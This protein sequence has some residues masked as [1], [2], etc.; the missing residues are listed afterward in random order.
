MRRLKS[1]KLFIVFLLAFISLLSYAVITYC[2]FVADVP[3]TSRSGVNGSVVT[4]DDEK[5]DFY[6]YNSLNYTETNGTLPSGNDQDIYNISNMVKAKITYSGIDT[7]NNN[8]KGVVSTT[9]NYDTYVYYHWY[10]V[11]DGKVI[12]PLID[13]PFAKR[14]SGKGFNGWISNQTGVTVK[15]DMDI[16]ERYAEVLVTSNGSVNACGL[17]AISF[18]SF[19]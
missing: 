18:S 5:A 15:L 17:S 10:P 1:N 9:E 8:I 19:T 11:K 7:I 12:I 2:Q 6:Y 16:Y 14:P 4:V 3:T 13:N